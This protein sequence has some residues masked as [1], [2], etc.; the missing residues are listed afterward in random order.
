MTSFVDRD[1][2]MRFRG[3]GI[4]HRTTHEATQCFLNDRD[5]LDDIGLDSG[6]IRNDDDEI[7]EPGI[8]SSTMQATTSNV[9][10]LGN[11][12]LEYD[13]FGYSGIEQREEGEDDKDGEQ[14]GENEDVDKDD[15]NVVDDELGAEDGENSDEELEGFDEF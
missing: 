15:D 10:E 6:G 2:F 13:N 8:S 12:E 11:D 9:L 1:I 7:D 3:G 4:G 5:L 14:A